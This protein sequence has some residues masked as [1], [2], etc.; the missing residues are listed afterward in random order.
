MEISVAARSMTASG[1]LASVKWAATQCPELPVANFRYREA[2][3]AI[4]SAA[5]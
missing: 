4:T 5:V 3:R 1:R 2:G